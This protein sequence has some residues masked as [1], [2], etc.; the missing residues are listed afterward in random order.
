LWT[1]G[2]VAGVVVTTVIFLVPAFD[3]AAQ[4]DAWVYVCL[5]ISAALLWFVAST[6]KL[7]KQRD[8]TVSDCRRWEIC[9]E[10]NAAS[11]AELEK[12]LKLKARAT[13]SAPSNKFAVAKREFA[14][15]FHPD[16]NRFSGI[17]K[18]IRAELFKEFW[19][20]LEKIDRGNYEENRTGA[21]QRGNRGQSQ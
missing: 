4:C 20:T 2:P 18:L 6:I 3:V 12:Q 16:S 1:G 13:N 19:A 14:R 21:P 5:A 10:Q 15:M 7:S 11:V 8:A 9:A 17:E